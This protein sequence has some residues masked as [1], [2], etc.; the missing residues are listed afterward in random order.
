G[1]Y[2][3]KGTHLIG[4]TELNDLPPGKALNS[5]CA[6]GAAFY[7][8]NPTLV[9]CQPAGYAFRGVNNATG[10]PNGTTI[11]HHILNQIRPYKGYQSI[12]MIQPRYDSNYHSLQ[13]SATHRFREPSQISVAYTWSKALTNARDDRSTPPQ[14]TYDL[15]S[16]YQRAAFD[17]THVLKISY[18]YELPFFRAQQGIA[19]KALG[20]WQISGITT[21]QT[22]IP[23]TATT[24]NLDYAG[25]GL[26][27]VPSVAARPNLLCDPNKNAP[28]SVNEYFNVACF[29]DNPPITGPGSTGLQNTPGTAGRGVIKGPGTTRFD[30]TL[31]RIVKFRE[32]LSLQ[33]R[34]EAFNIF[35]HTN[36]RSFTSTNVT[37]TAFGQ[38]GGVRDPRTMQLGAKFLF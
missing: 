25:L 23:F 32:S 7:A 21:V 2:G 10:N 11:D 24:S 37:S 9:Q 38:I 6:S 8:Q 1:Y 22:G 4:L 34:A 12:N 33:L 28:R 16:E 27:P 5:M 17:R 18:I 31:S 20:G 3:S 13:V 36:F 19:G 15:A 26:I 30:F 14:N 35:N 29:Q